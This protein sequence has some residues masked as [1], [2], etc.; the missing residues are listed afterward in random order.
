MAPF[1]RCLLFYRKR[2]SGQ[3]PTE[4]KVMPFLAV[5]AI[6]VGRSVRVPHASTQNRTGARYS[7]KCKA[8]DSK[9][10]SG[11]AYNCVGRNFVETTAT[12][13]LHRPGGTNTG[14]KPLKII[15]HLAL[16]PEGR[17]PALRQVVGRDICGKTAKG[18]PSVD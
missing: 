7:L 5:V 10:L 1:P 15:G 4:A 18:D 6:V 11:N 17:A 8:H 12:I 13:R 14:A 2:G 16:Q 9:S 3:V